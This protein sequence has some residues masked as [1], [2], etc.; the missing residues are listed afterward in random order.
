MSKEL[1]ER[2]RE[3]SAKRKPYATGAHGQVIG[4]ESYRIVANGFALECID[5]AADRIEELERERD[6][7][8]MDYRMKCDEEAK[9]SALVIIERDQLRAHINMLREAFQTFIDEHEECQDADEWMAELCSI[10]ALHVAGEALATTPEQSLAAYQNKA[11]DRIE[12][13]EEALANILVATSCH[14]L[15][16]VLNRARA[17]LGEDEK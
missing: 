15:I 6:A 2:L 9:G 14:D 3:L 12:K 11:T 4:M 8:Y 17:L 5:E 16:P 13:L 10:E 7:F 1:I